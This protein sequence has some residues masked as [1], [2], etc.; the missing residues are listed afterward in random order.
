MRTH[1][2]DAE[3][4]GMK[5]P[6]V[7]TLSIVGGVLALALVGI[8]VFAAYL[9]IS[10]T[11]LIDEWQ[12]KNDEAPV[13][14]DDG[15]GSYCEVEGRELPAGAH[16]DPLGNRPLQCADRWGWVEVVPTG[17]RPGGDTDCYPSD[18][19]LPEGWER[20]DSGS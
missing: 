16:W 4:E 14:W 6:L 5:K 9:A 1:L 15:P 17:Q 2:G 12:C 8:G 3:D 18:Q 13:L 20:V 7:R 19:E 10:G 11:P